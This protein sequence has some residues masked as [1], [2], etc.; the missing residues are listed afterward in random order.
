MS[1][2]TKFSKS[3]LFK[4]IHSGRF[5]RKTFGNLGKKV[6][7]DLGVPL[8]KVVFPKS[9]IKATCLQQ[10]NLTEK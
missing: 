9:V 7:L 4:L 5:F 1:T 10:M 2:D 3:Q 6:L 8:A